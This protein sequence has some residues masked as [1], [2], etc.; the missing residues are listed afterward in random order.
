MTVYTDLATEHKYIYIY[1]SNTSVSEDLTV[2][3]FTECLWLQTLAENYSSTWQIIGR[4]QSSLVR[5]TRPENEW[6]P[7]LCACAVVGP[8]TLRLQG[9]WKTLYASFIITVKI[10]L[11]IQSW[12]SN[13][14]TNLARRHS[15]CL[16]EKDCQRWCMK[17]HRV[18]FGCT[19][20]ASI[21]VLAD[22][23]ACFTSKSHWTAADNTTLH[24]PFE[25]CL[26]NHT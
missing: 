7:V 14:R 1:T 9:L 19:D 18:I 21:H 23:V 6:I 24:L 11:G 26:L 10:S 16:L 17:A 12:N 25:L 4:V 20:Y 8:S 15:I 22:Q 5:G 2:T 13:F 3:H